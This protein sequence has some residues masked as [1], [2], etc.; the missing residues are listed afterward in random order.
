MHGPCGTGGINS[1]L[2]KAFKL[3]PS[4]QPDLLYLRRHLSLRA[5][6]NRTIQSL[7]KRND[8]SYFEMHRANTVQLVQ[9]PVVRCGA[10]CG[11]VVV[12]WAQ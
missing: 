3:T 8:K 4:S 1:S 2:A 10:S 11:A 9:H 6:T 12:T 7:E 5:C